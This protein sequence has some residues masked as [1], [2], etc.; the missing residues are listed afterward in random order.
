MHAIGYRTWLRV[1][2]GRNLCDVPLEFFNVL[3]QN[4]ELHEVR[5]GCRHDDWNGGMLQC[6]SYSYTSEGTGQLCP[7]WVVDPQISSSV[8]SGYDPLLRISNRKNTDARDNNRFVSRN[9]IV[10]GR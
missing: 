9:F 10:P 6:E 7:E 5:N 4:L 1:D 8:Q 3:W 2:D